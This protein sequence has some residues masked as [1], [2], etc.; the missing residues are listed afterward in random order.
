LIK[1]P[2]GKTIAYAYQFTFGNLGVIIGLIWLPTVLSAVGS[3]FTQTFY[4]QDLLVA[5]TQAN[6]SAA[7]PGLTSLLAWLIVAVLLSA[8]ANVAV[9][10]RAMGRQTGS[11]YYHFVLGPEEFRVFGAQ[12]AFY[13]TMVLL[14]VALLIACLGLLQTAAAGGS[15]A[16]IARPVLLVAT[17]AGGAFILFVYARL[18]FLLL[19]ATLIEE[20]IGLARSWAL[21]QGN[22]WRIAAI[23][24]ACWGPLLLVVGIAR[25]VIMGPDLYPGAGGNPADLVAPFL[26][27]LT[28]APALFAYRALQPEVTGP[29]SLF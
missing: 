25:V 17:L 2:V 28:V 13:A 4:Y 5:Q 23:M 27:G 22:F 18:S 10:Q 15:A 9:L 1:I 19:P 21:S 26:A 6:P 11:P 24:L 3:F 14:S 16:A 12:I 20:R 29:E 7:G 8:I